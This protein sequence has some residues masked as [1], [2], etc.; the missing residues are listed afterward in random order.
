M[1]TQ[2]TGRLAAPTGTPWHASDASKPAKIQSAGVMLEAGTATIDPGV[3]TGG[4][5]PGT[6]QTRT[7]TTAAMT[8]A[9]TASRRRVGTVR[10]DRSR[11]IYAA[12]PFSP[13]SYRAPTHTA[14][15]AHTALLLLL[16][17][18]P[19]VIVV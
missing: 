16:A 17:V 7:P 15:P 1:T 10:A 6:D 2:R 14:A 3:G 13:P 12:A 8:S 4:W 11:D 19:L 5:R 18:G 9:A